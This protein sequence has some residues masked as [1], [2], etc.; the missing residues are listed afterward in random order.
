M[1]YNDFIKSLNSC[2][3]Y[4]RK[5]L[6]SIP[7]ISFI[8]GSGFFSLDEELKKKKEFSYS[9][10]P[11]FPKSSIPGQESKLVYGMWNDK[12][13]LIFKKRL[14]FYEG[15]TPLQCTFPIWL[16]KEVGAK[17]LF[18]FC[19]SGG[20]NRELNEGD[21][22][23]IRDQINLTGQNP[24][25]EIPVDSRNPLFLNTSSLFDN[26]LKEKI[27]KIAEENNIRITE[28]VYAGLTGPSYETPAEV[29]M[30]SKIDADIVGMSIVFE[31]IIA[32]YLNLKTLALSIVA[33]KSTS[34][35][36]LSHEMVVENIE[37]KIPS[38]RKLIKELL[39]TL[40]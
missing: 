8:L 18:L 39:K 1:N 3:N 15:F 9:S 20:I 28:G 34:H 25:R 16:S 14:H 21:I 12:E 5:N 10:L 38:I 33:N 26:D 2:R 11:C 32:R 17:Y 29:N 31:S 24:L 23:V 35:S 36:E 4:L 27:L 13:I 40:K 30:L 7:L 19:A 22:V 37:K 6:P